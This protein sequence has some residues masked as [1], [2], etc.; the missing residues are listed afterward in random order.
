[1]VFSLKS[2]PSSMIPTTSNLEVI[3]VRIGVGQLYNCMHSLYSPNACNDYQASLL[4]HLNNIVSTSECVIIVGDF[5]LV[6]PHWCF[7]FLKFL[8]QSYIWPS[9]PVYMLL[10]QNFSKMYYS[11]LLLLLFAR[12]VQARVAKSNVYMWVGCLH[13]NGHLYITYG[14]GCSTFPVKQ[15][16]L[17]VFLS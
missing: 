9:L 10:N 6:F 8:V 7:S 15:D 17:D 11:S 13:G 3:T 12:S 2:V 1:M 16:V 4:M 5:T 14:S